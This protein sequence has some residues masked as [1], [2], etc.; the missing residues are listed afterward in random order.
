MNEKRLLILGSVEDFT[1]LTQVA[2][3]KGIY[4]V[5]ADGYPG[6]AKQYASKAYTVNLNDTD[7]IDRIIKTEKID[8]VL[9]SFSDNL[10]EM[11][12]HTSARNGLP[13]FCPE[14]K[15]RYLR[16]KVLMKQMLQ[17]LNI[18]TA[19]GQILDIADMDTQQL[20]VPYPCV[21]KPVDGWGS[22]GMKIVHNDT[23]LREY[24]RQSAD[25]S[26]SGSKAMAE[27]INQ[28]YEI[29]IMSWI[30]NGKVYLMEFGDRETSG[31]TETSLPYL[32]REVFPTVFYHELKSTVLDYLKRIADYIGIQEGP[33]SMQVFYHEGQL[34]VGEVAGRFFGLGQ[35][36][37]PVINGID[38]NELLV[39]MIYF[40]EENDAILEKVDNDLDHCS[41][42]LYLKAKRGIVKSIGNAEQFRTENVDELRI[43]ATPG[44]STTYIP[45]T[46][47]IYAHFPTRAE[48][49]AYTEHVYNNLFVEGIEGE[50][51]VAPNKLVEYGETQ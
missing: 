32:S 22:K 28:G 31:A 42:A 29:N 19:P 49:D 24:I 50:N 46:V 3:R 44:Q 12:V 9:T 38:L 10:F 1:G 35:G 7:L 25:C 8:H 11:M 33:L 21:I 14:D 2:V 37:V 4:T 48:A 51:L 41:V 16:D 40:P 26:T 18:R 17:E 30:K 43:F 23:Q 34:T 20:S 13:C 5:V 27:S 45:W 47:R 15:V 6:E 36:I 39:N